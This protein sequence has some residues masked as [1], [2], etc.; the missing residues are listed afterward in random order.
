ML[1]LCRNLYKILLF[2]MPKLWIN[3]VSQ[4]RKFQQ[5]HSFGRFW[6]FGISAFHHYIR[7]LAFHVR[8]DRFQQAT[9][10]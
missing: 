4:F 2:I 9:L 6:H 1:K 5:F 10:A 7:V 8:P 3:E